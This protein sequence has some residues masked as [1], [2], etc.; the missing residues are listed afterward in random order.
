M[1]PCFEMIE[2]MNT[3][4]MIGVPVILHSQQSKGTRPFQFMQNVHTSVK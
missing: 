1:F 2:V 4:N 3:M